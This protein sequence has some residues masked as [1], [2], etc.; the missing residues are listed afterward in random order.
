MRLRSLALLTAAAVLTTSACV[1]TSTETRP[2]PRPSVSPEEVTPI[3]TPDDAPEISVVDSSPGGAKESDPLWQGLAQA[4][5]EK[6]PAYLKTWV[7]TANP[8]LPDSGEVTVTP[9]SPNSVSVTLDA[10]NV[11]TDKAPFVLI[12]GLFDV[13]EIGESAY[14]LTT[15]NSDDIPELDPQG[16][17]DEARCTADDAQDRI[18]LAADDLSADPGKREEFRQQ[19]GASPQVWWGIQMTARSLGEEGGVAGDYLT[20]A[21][22]AY[23]GQ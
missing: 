13:E 20:E 16:P 6:K 17:D 15:V 19:W 18:S 21:C 5:A 4:A 10:G 2:Q 23:L 9:D 11:T 8:D 7:H 3:A 22:G 1:P 14:T 12:H